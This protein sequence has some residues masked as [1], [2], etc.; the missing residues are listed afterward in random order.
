M[1]G[2]PYVRLKQGGVLTF[3]AS[4]LC[5]TKG[6]KEANSAWKKGVVEPRAQT[7]DSCFSL[8]GPGQCSR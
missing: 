4:I 7:A 2:V 5:T 3:K 6:A 1:G 8:I